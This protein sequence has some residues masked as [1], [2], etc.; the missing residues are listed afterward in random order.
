MAGTNFEAFHST[1]IIRFRQWD[2]Y[3]W[4]RNSVLPSKTRKIMILIDYN[5]TTI[6]IYIYSDTVRRF[7]GARGSIVG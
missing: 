2:A 7:S 3:H 4:L 5:T 6:S 1:P